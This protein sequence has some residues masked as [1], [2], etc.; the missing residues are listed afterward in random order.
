MWVSPHK[1]HLENKE[2]AWYTSQKLG[3]ML[4]EKHERKLGF[5]L[6]KEERIRAH[7]GK[8]KVGMA[9]GKRGT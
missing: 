9:L 3:F 7:A 8:E 1:V 6:A 5:T 2:N 4:K